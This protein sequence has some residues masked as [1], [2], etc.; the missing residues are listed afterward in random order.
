MHDQRGGDRY[1]R[2][3][4]RE[5]RR[6]NEQAADPARAD[7]DRIRDGSRGGRH[8]E[9]ENVD[10]HALNPESYSQASEEDPH[11]I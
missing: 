8:H 11:A 7:A 9:P 4:E 1:E 6:S 3:Y 2:E 10:I 5:R